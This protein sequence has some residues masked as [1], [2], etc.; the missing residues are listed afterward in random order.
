ME[1]DLLALLEAQC[2][3]VHPDVAPLGTPK[4]YV[5]WQQLGGPS[6]RYADN[7]AMD[8]RW[9]LMQVSVWSTTREEALT[10]I[11][12]IEE[13]L[14]ASLAFDVTPQGEAHST[15]EP[16]TKL[17]GCIQRFEIWAAR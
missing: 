5:T 15:Q 6:M 2:D 3:E 10:L 4:P 1:S 9:A 11:R 14:C 17:C 12:G 8:S 7:T 16:D 13:A